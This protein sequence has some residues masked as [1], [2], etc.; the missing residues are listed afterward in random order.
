MANGKVPPMHD[1]AKTSPAP[2][3]E[4]DS[5]SRAKAWL[6]QTHS[7]TLPGWAFAAAGAFAVLLMFVALD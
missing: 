5:L 7:V 2:P 3:T 1:D 4:T 6:R